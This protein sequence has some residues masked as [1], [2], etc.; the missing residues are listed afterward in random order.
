M[1]EYEP[2]VDFIARVMHNVRAYEALQEEKTRF[3]S[4]LLG[5]R[6]FQCAMSACGVLFGIF[7]TPVAC[8]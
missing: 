6:F 5:S 7:C 2:S 3:A 1:K 8:I 4:R